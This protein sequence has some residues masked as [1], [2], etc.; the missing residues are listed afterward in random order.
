[1]EKEMKTLDEVSAWLATQP[2]QDHPWAIFWGVFF[3]ILALTIWGYL[4]FDLW[5]YSVEKWNKKH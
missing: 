5:K 1:M 2:P 3:L 4:I